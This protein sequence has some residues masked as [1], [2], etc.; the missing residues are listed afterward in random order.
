MR[1][2]GGSETEARLTGGKFITEKISEVFP[3]AVSQEYASRI[4]GFQLSERR[5]D[6]WFDGGNLMV[7]SVKWIILLPGKKIRSKLLFFSPSFPSI[8][9]KMKKYDGSVS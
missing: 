8:T 2:K 4:I 7:K 6:T 1:L 5:K 3:R 9:E